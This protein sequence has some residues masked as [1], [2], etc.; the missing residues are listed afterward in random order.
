MNGKSEIGLYGSIEGNWDHFGRGMLVSDII[1]MRIERIGDTLS[2]YCSSDGDNWFTCGE[3]NFPAEG[4]IQIGI[5]A[6]GGLGSLGGSVPT[7]IR[8]DYFRV[9]RKPA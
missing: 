2:A 6:I 7:A 4:P 1:Y 9:L 5:N 8:F 3:V